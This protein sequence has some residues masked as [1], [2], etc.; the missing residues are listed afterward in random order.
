ME[1]KKVLLGNRTARSKEDVRLE[2]VARIEEEGRREKEP[3][4]E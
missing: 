1:G 4:M 3:I 2:V